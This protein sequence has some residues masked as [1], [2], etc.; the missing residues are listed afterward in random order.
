MFSTLALIPRGI[1]LTILLRR[2][3]D[4]GQRAFTLLTSALNIPAL[5][6]K[7]ASF[8][9]GAPAQENLPVW[10]RLFLSQ[11]ATMA[12]VAWCMA[13][14]RSNAE[15]LLSGSQ[16]RIVMQTSDATL[17]EVLAAF[18]STFSLEVKLNGVTTRTFT[19]IYSGSVRQVLSRLLSGEDYILSSDADGMR[20]ILIGRSASDNI[21]RWSGLPPAAPAAQ[22]NAPQQPPAVRKP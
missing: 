5:Q 8:G 1:H 17:A 18:R 12:L 4:G 22:P 10:R 11:V 3:S 21:A 16:D 14:G 6:L 13:C 15:V 20:I 7:Y 2:S 9:V 19:G